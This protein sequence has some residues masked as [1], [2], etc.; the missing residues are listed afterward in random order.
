MADTTLTVTADTTVS[1]KLVAACSG[2][3]DVPGASIKAFTATAGT[4]T[5]PAAGMTLDLSDLFPN[6]VLMVL[7]TPMYDSTLDAG[8][9][10]CAVVYVPAASNAPAS[11]K[12]YAIVSDDGA[13][14]MGQFAAGGTHTV[15]GF[16]VKGV[17]I[18]Y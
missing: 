2:T 12:L 5:F 3:T 7:T 15:T 8:D 6:K 1:S 14:D 13:D 18:G 16:V 9:D 10:A 4:G 11:G 17:A